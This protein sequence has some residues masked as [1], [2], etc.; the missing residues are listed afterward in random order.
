[1]IY[2]A[3]PLDSSLP[4][5]SRRRRRR[6]VPPA[7]QKEIV[8][9]RRASERR[10]R[11]R[12]AVIIKQKTMVDA[13][14][15]GGMKREGGGV[16]RADA[17]PWEREGAAASGYAA[18]PRGKEERREKEERRREKERERERERGDAVWKAMGAKD[19]VPRTA[20]DLIRALCPTLFPSS[21][22]S[23]SPSLPPPSLPPSL[24]PRPMRRRPPSALVA[25]PPGSPR[26]PSWL[27]YLVPPLRA[28][29][30]FSPLL[31]R[32]PSPFSPSCSSITTLAA[33]LPPIIIF[34]SPWCSG[35][36]TTFSLS[37]SLPFGPLDLS[38]RVWLFVFLF[39][40]RR[41]VAP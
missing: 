12:A 35:S 9:R 28:R 33:R 21:G 30:A 5:R 40:S 17:S 19:V 34:N 41:C 36:A 27:S 25:V 2:R 26:V 14:N 8:E 38:L 24:P 6:R 13:D 16:T 20:I 37:L 22:R 32:P 29:I 15:K 10:D 7:S 11:S 18:G 4:W 31:P 3:I 1:M 39:Y 23:A